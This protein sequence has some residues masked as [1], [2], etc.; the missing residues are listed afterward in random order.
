MLAAVCVAEQRSKLR[1]DAAAGL[2]EPPR[3][4]EV[5]ERALAEEQGAEDLPD[6]DVRAWGALFCAKV[7]DSRSRGG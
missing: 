2:Q 6:D 3:V 1:G 5:V 4:A 7:H